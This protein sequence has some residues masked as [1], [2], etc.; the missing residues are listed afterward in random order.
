MHTYKSRIE[1]QL[2]EE[3]V[4]NKSHQEQIKKLRTDVQATESQGDK[5]AGIHKLLNEKENAIQQLK[6]K[7]NIPSTQLI[8]AF[9]LV[10]LEKENEGL[11]NELNDCKDKLLK[12]SEKEK[13]TVEKR[14]DF[15]SR[16]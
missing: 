12:F 4:E 11:S 16:E 2:R 7:L 8:Q 14:H 3:K 15:G 13:K 5:G 10:E 6:K 1:N 9:E